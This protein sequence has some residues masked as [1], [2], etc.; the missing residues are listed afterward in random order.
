M[1][2]KLSA[3]L[4]CIA[5]FVLCNTTNVKAQ[6]IFSIDNE[7]V[8]KDEFLNAYNKNKTQNESEASFREYLNLYINYKLKVKEAKS[9]KLDSLAQI[10]TDI[11]NF[12]KQL[13]EGFLIDEEATAK[14]LNEALERGSKDIHVVHFFAPLLNK[15]D[16]AKAN[17]ALLIVYNNLKIGKTDYSNI[18]SQASAVYPVKYS[19]A[20]FLT[21]FSVPYNFEN[22]I[23]NLKPGDVSKPYKTTSGLH[24][25]K[26]IEIRPDIGKWKIAQI[27]IATEPT[28][29][30]TEINNAKNKADSVFNL[31]KNGLDFSTA[32]MKFSDDKLSYSI[33]GEIPE[34]GS[35]RFAPDFEKQVTALSKDGDISAPF[36]TSYGFHILKR[37]HVEPYAG[38][39]DQTLIFEMRQK[40]LKDDRIQTSIDKFNDKIASVV[41]VKQ[42]SNISKKD[43][44]RLADTV[45]SD[46]TLDNA[47]DFK[48]S[49]VKVLQY[50]NSSATVQDWLKYVRNYYL[51]KE[52]NKGDTGDK[53]W[54]KFVTFSHREYY[55]N[56]LE[57]FNPQFKAQLTEFSDG[58]LLFEIMERKIWDKSA[59][60]TLQLKNYYQAHKENY[61]WQ[62]SAEILTVSGSDKKQ[63]EQIISILKDGE[64]IEKLI[65]QFPD[66]HI[67]SGRFELSQ[68]AGLEKINNIEKFVPYPLSNSVESNSGFFMVLDTYPA[69]EQKSFE[70][71]KGSVISDYQTVLENEWVKMLHKKYLIKINEPAVKSTFSSLSK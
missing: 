39:K 65:E 44:L 20:G 48:E 25:F 10:K 54:N 26:A 28:A 7:K 68:I 3:K 24:I 60:D 2:L 41:S 21:V 37:I 55:K 38:P 64:K 23:Y 51:S 13:Q 62:K 61:K 52:L 53:L 30:E 69:G 34:F 27:L 33:G 9:L 71:A 1:T 15:S 6:T 16:S 56:N 70:D 50:K 5:T 43:L 19:D 35:G 17:D 14:L 22:I 32:A 12:R 18:A 29:S 59:S 31:L 42:L 63:E 8:L 4:L 47:E 58:N 66:V 67:D 40:L 46:L 57:Q 36:K 45:I 11:Q 49:K